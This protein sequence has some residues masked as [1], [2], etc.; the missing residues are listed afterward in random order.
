MKEWSNPWNPFNSAKVLLWKEHLDACAKEDYLPPVTID[1]DPANRCM[2]DC[3]HC[4]AY[5]MITHSGKVMSGKHMI[6]LIDFLADWRDSTRYG[7]PNSA[8]VSGGGE[9]YMNKNINALF[10]HM[11]RKGMEIGPISTGFLL[12]DEDIDIIARTCRWFGFSVDAAYPHTYATI[13]GIKNDGSLAKVLENIKKL[14]KRIE[15]HKSKCDVA[16]KFLLTPDNAN[17]ILVAIDLAKNLGVKDFHLRPAGWDNLSKVKEK[18]DYSKL[19]HSINYQIEEGMKLETKDFRVF[20]IRHKFNPDFSRKINFSR[21]WAIPLLPTF[22]ADGNVHMCFDMRSRED[23]IMSS[24]DPDPSEILKF[25]NTDAH[26]EMVRSI[27]V[28]D[29][30]RCTFGAY[31]EVIEQVI[32]NDSMCMYFP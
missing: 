18:P 31:N 24:H 27:K 3:P 5:D 30:P 26:R 7:V 28:K 22:G 8:C 12:T 19:V 32:M 16:F 14:V 21:C 13:K 20:G 25:W 17:E 11:H 9:P 2:F 15:H 29:C 1:L 6:K 23:L 4:N 10:E